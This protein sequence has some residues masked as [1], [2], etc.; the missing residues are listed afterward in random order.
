MAC[1]IETYSA[2]ET[3]KALE[4]FDQFHDDYVAGI[5]V[6]FENYKALNDRGE[7]TGIGD[8]QKTIILLINT[9]PYGREHDRIIYMKLMGVRYFDISTPEGMGNMWGI[10]QILALPE[11]DDIKIDIYFI[12]GNAKFIVVCSKILL[13]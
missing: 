1:N 7:S 8:A 5:E 6:R 12:G 2:E 3:N 4:H 13:Y 11:G 10:N 9:N